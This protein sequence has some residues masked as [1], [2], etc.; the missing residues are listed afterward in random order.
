[1]TNQSRVTRAILFSLTFI[2]ISVC[3]IQAQKS[4]S[5][6]YSQFGLGELASLGTARSKAMGGAG[7]ALR[8]GFYL[9]TLNPASYTTL[10]S[11]SFIFDVGVTGSFTQLKDNSIKENSKRANFE[12]FAL[13][14]SVKKWWAMSAGIRKVTNVGYNLDF[15]SNDA[16]AGVYTTKYKGEGGVN[17]VYLS[18]AFLIRPNL[19]VGVNINYNWGRVIK[20]REV[21]FQGGRGLPFYSEE[22]ITVSNLNFDMGVQYTLQLREKKQLTI[23]AVVGNKTDLSENYS[24][25]AYKNNPK[26]PLLETKSDSKIALP[27]SFGIGLAFSNKKIVLSSDI[28]YQTW[29][30][31]EKENTGNEKLAVQL[32]NSYKFDLGL[33]Y[34]PNRFSGRRFFDR[35]SYR[36]G[37]FYNK[38]NLT[39]NGTQLQEIGVTAGLGIPIR[40]SYVN[41]AFELGTRGTT[42]DNLIRE[43]YAKINIGFTLFENWF[44]KV[45]YE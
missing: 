4:T 25:L 34:T 22:K 5:S 24:F 12:Y 45:L 11:T 28:N 29:G 30:G 42:N 17:K 36:T 33:E 16:K 9:N 7:I 40:G 27:N 19:S 32:K 23:G 10:D 18:N 31:T 44:Q 43:N 41:L 1:M 37:V 3:S 20:N 38:A 13:G 6:P 26:A 8:D 21:I 14:F 2:L 39:I 35:V 15:I